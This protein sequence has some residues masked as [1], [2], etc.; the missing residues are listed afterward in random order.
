MNSMSFKKRL[1]KLPPHVLLITLSI[2]IGF[3]AGTAAYF[4][5]KVIGIVAELFIKHV[6]DGQINWWLIAMPVA[7]IIITGIFTRYIIHT[8][9]THG[10]A[11]LVADLRRKAYRLR[12]NIAYS[13]MVG[14]TLT[15][16]LGGSSGSEG[17]I[18]YTGAG[19]GSLVAQKLELSP[20]FTKTLIGCG[21]GGAIAGIF[22]SPMGGLM[23][24][25]ECLGMILSTI[26]VIAVLL[27]CLVAYATVFL[28]RGFIFDH[29][30]CPTESFDLS[31]LPYVIALG[32]FC[33]IYSLYYNSIINGSDTFFRKIKNPWLS[34]LMGGLVTGLCIMIFPSLYGVGYPIIGDIIHGDYSSISSGSFLSGVEPGSWGMIGAAAGVLVL[35]CWACG[36]TNSSGGVGG[37]FSP[38]LFAGAVAGFL[39]CALCS[40]VLG[41]EIPVTVFAFLGTAGVMAGTIEAPIM[42]IFLVMDLGQSYDYALPIGIVVL[43]SFLTVKGGYRLGMPTARMF[44]HLGWILDGRDLHN[45]RR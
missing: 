43:V 25:L 23:F 4:F 20:Y 13:P 29:T 22:M 8:N 31:L 24:S 15:L 32:I 3:L 44:R 16:G 18:A 21:A 1:Q 14:G 30:Y 40:K 6:K 42:T 17:P 7:G 10:C 37:D 28:F 33:G 45:S 11:Q 5:R 38:T 41:I 36:A 27:S 19:I 2:V 35:K 12:P 9:L 39:F 34:N 26:P